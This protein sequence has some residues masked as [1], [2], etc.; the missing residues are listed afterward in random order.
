MAMIPSIA[1]PA[2]RAPKPVKGPPTL[3]SRTL[4]INPFSNLLACQ[5]IKSAMPYYVLS[6]DDVILQRSLQGDCSSFRG[7]NAKPAVSSSGVSALSFPSSN[8]KLNTVH[9]QP[10]SML[11]QQS[12][13]KSCMKNSNVTRRWIND[14]IKHGFSIPATRYNKEGEGCAGRSRKQQRFPACSSKTYF[15]SRKN[16]GSYYMLKKAMS[17]TKTRH[18]PSKLTTSAKSA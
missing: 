2:E 6:L 10:S 9:Y 1:A 3:A 14:N 12:N 17:Q 11:L 8:L 18:L 4:I 16:L 7:I 15:R 5:Q 13:L